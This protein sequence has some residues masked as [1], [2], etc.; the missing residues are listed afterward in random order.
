MRAT[1]LSRWIERLLWLIAVTSIGICVFVF[2]DA[3]IYQSKLNGQFKSAQRQRTLP[4]DS[5]RPAVP[6]NLEGAS[7][8]DPPAIPVPREPFLGRLHIPRLGISTIILD[9]VDDRTLRRGIGHIPGTASPGELGNIGI[10]G[11]RDTFFRAL[12]GIHNG[13]EIT[14]ETIDKQYRYVV[15]SVI[16]VDPDAVDVL[17][18][19]GQPA[20]TLVTCY[21]FNLIGPASRRLV[22]RAS[23]S[24][25]RFPT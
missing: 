24:P 22:V 17:D 8:I 6:E 1:N 10:A 20:L 7:P 3:E 18:D 11:H 5:V 15:F 13:D 9:G 2:V 19:I 25:R 16:I 23:T 21:P 4:A 12:G 14:I